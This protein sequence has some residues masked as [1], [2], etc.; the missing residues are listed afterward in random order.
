MS[1]EGLLLQLAQYYL[2]RGWAPIPLPYREKA[3]RRKGWQS[4]R[5]T[6]DELPQHFNGQQ[7]IGILLGA[8]SGGLIDIDLDCPE[9]IAVAETFLAPTPLRFGRASKRKSHWL[10]RVEGTAPKTEK[11][12]DPQ[13]RPDGTT[14]MIVE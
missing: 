10:Y 14:A 12:P 11:F 9:A 6:A 8:M 4:W 2:G 13:K 3:T 7:N 5:I 1:T